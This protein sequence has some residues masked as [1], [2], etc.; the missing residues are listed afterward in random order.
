[1][2]RL[3]GRENKNGVIQHIQL[4]NTSLN[5][6]VKKGI[7]QKMNGGVWGMLYEFMIIIF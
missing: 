2:D 7:I 6:I 4:L 1:M 3:N 5:I